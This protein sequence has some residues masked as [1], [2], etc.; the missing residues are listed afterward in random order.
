VWRR[1]GRWVV[2]VMDAIIWGWDMLM[3]YVA[4]LFLIPLCMIA[5]LRV[6][7]IATVWSVF[8]EAGLENAWFGLMLIGAPAWLALTLYAR[9]AGTPRAVAFRDRLERWKWAIIWAGCA[10]MGVYAVLAL[11]FGT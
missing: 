9:F 10:G 3:M 1:L 4:A 2:I 11:I 8:A 6:M 5:S 7:G